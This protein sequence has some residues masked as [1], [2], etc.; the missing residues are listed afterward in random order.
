MTIVIV[1]RLDT[2]VYPTETYKGTGRNGREKNIGTGEVR[3]AA[4][5]TV[6]KAAWGMEIGTVED[7]INIKVGINLTKGGNMRRPL[8]LMVAVILLITCFGCFVVRDRRGYDG[9]D[10]GG[11]WDHDRGEYGDRDRGGHEGRR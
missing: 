6:I 8:V 2:N 7:E 5:D 11:H 1:Y 9:R 10:R 3:K 4:V